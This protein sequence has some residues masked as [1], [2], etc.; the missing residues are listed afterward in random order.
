LS[1]IGTG[2]QSKAV[3]TRRP[4]I[5]GDMTDERKRTQVDVL[6][7]APGPTTLSGLF[8]PMLSKDMVIGVI[9][10]Q[11]YQ[12][13]RFSKQDAE[14]LTL[15]GN[16]TA[17][18][19]ENSRLVQGLQETYR[20][21]LASYD[22]TII[23]WTLALDLRDQE[24]EGHS[25][26]VADLTVQ[27]ARRWGIG[28]DETVHIRRGALLH[29]IGKL[30]VPD[31]ILNKPGPLTD[32]EWVTMRRHPQAAFDMLSQIHYLR[33]ALDIPYCHHEKWNGSGY[34]R[35]MQGEQI[36]LSA[37]IFA[38]VDVWDALTSDR[39]YRA[40]WSQARALEYI[41]SQS[42]EHFDPAVVA[43]FMDL[44]NDDMGKSV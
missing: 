40:R 39:P 1:P 23:G 16:T 22:A 34:P 10:V 7:G 35:Q 27:L 41:Q 2:N 24:T 8:V 13:N 32:A 26:R 15:V 36:P 30:G 18:A 33:P 43:A 25:L 29:D 14:V 6:I 38:I 11:S 31:E 37:R 9:S 3:H 20:D 19:I 42:G 4:V 12:A 28:E 21:L 5:I 17:M 44:L